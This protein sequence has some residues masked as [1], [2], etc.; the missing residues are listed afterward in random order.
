MKTLKS[1]ICILSVALLF[2]ACQKPDIINDEVEAPETEITEMNDLQI[3]KDFDWKTTKDVSVKVEGKLAAAV[4]IK[5][6][7]GNVYQKAMLTP[8]QTY[9]TTITVPSYVDEI[10]F[11]SN[12]MSVPTPIS[13]NLVEYTFN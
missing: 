13:N 1:L 5:G 12:G 7:D 8:G 4:L 3:D 10:V 2:G 6:A 9:E 11:A